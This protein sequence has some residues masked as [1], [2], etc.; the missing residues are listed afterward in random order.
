MK[1]LL[2]WYD[3]NHRSLPWRLNP[4]PYWVWISEM[5]CQQ[6][7][8]VTVLPYFERWMARFPNVESLAAASIDEVLALWQGLGYYRRARSIHAAAN[9][10]AAQGWPSS[11]KEW[12][13]LPGVGRYS[14]AAIASTTLGEP[15]ALVDGN[16]ER[17]FARLTACPEGKPA[18][19]RLAWTW[20]EE[21][22]HQ[23]DPGLWN[24][25]LME[26]GALVCRPKAPL[27]DECPVRSHCRAYALDTPEAFP[28]ASAKPESVRLDLTLS[29]HRQNGKVALVQQPE[30]EWWTGLWMFPI[31][32]GSPTQ[33]SL[34]TV[35]AQVTHHKLTLHVCLVGKSPA[36]A[37]W[38]EENELNTVAMPAPIRRAWSIVLRDG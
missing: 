21:N 25:A 14:S 28:V 30:G 3:A 38:V 19:H 6:T 1:Q 13:L 37:R 9:L 10:I 16:V 20:A 4:D 36:D 18:L 17:V 15:V 23:S 32:K 33:R 35:R 29:V 5:M 24:Q 31:H 12:A 7:Q 11:A 22:L 34:G 2:A 26:L 8:I 27:C